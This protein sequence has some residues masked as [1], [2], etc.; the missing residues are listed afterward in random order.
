MAS[1]TFKEIISEVDNANKGNRDPHGGMF[2][3]CCGKD[4]SYTMDNDKVGNVGE[5]K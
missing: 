2:S 5:V 1:G 3:T 4:S